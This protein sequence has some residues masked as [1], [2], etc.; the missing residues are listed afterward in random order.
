MRN[1]RVEP[2]S[3][4]PQLEFGFEPI[5]DGFGIN[6]PIPEPALVSIPTQNLV[7]RLSR[8]LNSRSLLRRGSSPTL[9]SSPLWVP[10][11]LRPLL[12]RITLPG[13]A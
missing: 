1:S 4:K 2:D 12:R 5:D 13:L 9:E 8:F 10:L 7:W 6:V 11:C 3:T